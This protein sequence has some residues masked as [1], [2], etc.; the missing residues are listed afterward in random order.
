MQA[1]TQHVPPQNALASSAQQAVVSMGSV[2]RFSTHCWSLGQHIPVS[3][4]YCG[5]PPASRA[6]DCSAGFNSTER[7]FPRLSLEECHLWN[8]LSVYNSGGLQKLET[9]QA[10]DTPGTR[11]FAVSWLCSRERPR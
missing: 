8:S 9:Q 11:P 10:K 2:S 5:S 1:P 6:R 4:Q 7:E 3:K